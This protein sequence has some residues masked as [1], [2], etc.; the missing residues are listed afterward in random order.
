[1]SRKRFGP[2]SNPINHSELIYYVTHPDGRQERLVHSF[3]RC[4]L[5]RF[6]AE[7]LL[8][9]CGLGLTLAPIGSTLP[10]HITY[11]E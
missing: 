9:R 10:H 5:F 3:P 1:M 2:G 8:A 6:E 7:H 4:Y 11:R